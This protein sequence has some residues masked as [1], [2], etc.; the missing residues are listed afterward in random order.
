MNG[1][2]ACQTAITF[3]PKFP[4]D[5]KNVFYMDQSFTKIDASIWGQHDRFLL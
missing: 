3:K 5:I 1:M 4:I 2:H